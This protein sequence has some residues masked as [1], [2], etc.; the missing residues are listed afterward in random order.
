MKV[1]GAVH[2]NAL[3]QE[4]LNYSD[5]RWNTGVTKFTAKTLKSMHPA[6]WWKAY[7]RQW[8]LLREVAVRI[9]CMAAR[10]AT[11]WSPSS[12]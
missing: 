5:G 2:L 1:H 11:P 9:L 12:R 10:E 4:W 8:P 7:G 6:A 3:R